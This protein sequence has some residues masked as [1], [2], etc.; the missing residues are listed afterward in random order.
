MRNF[1]SWSAA[2]FAMAGVSSAMATDL[3]TSASLTE[4]ARPRAAALYNW[5]GFYIGANVGY[6]WGNSDFTYAFPGITGAGSTSPRG[7]LG[8]V[9]GGYN[10]QSRQL[11][12]GIEGDIQFTD[13]DN[14]SLALCL[15]VRA[16]TRT[17]FVAKQSLPWFATLRGRVGY[18]SADDWLIYFTGGVAWGRLKTEVTGQLAGPGTE[19]AA[20][21]ST[22]KT[23]WTIGG[24]VE[25][26][27]GGRITLK[28]EYLY[29][30]L[31]SISQ[32][33]PV[34]AATLRMNSSVN[35]HVIRVGAN[36]KL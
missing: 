5:T 3:S 7:I 10:W 9:G 35:D 12:L 15:N 30:D 17:F 31:G 27:L 23:G 19:F 28:V 2:L 33:V 29:I 26:P 8:G 24:G 6:S 16:C 22:T 36:L 25:R 20:S 34:G 11:L 18:A 21:A 13:Q 4:R 1:L 32:T 14:D